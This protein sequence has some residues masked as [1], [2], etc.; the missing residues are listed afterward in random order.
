MKSH[1]EPTYSRRDLIVAWLVAREN[2]NSSEAVRDYHQAAAAAFEKAFGIKLDAPPPSDPISDN[3]GLDCLFLRTVECYENTRSPFAGFMAAGRT[4]V[5]IY[6]ESCLPL[7]ET[8]SGLRD[9]YLEMMVKIVDEIWKED[10]D[11]S[12]T[13]SQLESCGH[14]DWNA[15][16]PL[17]DW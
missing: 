16:N 9:D 2:K 15:P 3:D 1:K 8:I 5:R 6:R 14:P 11:R 17:D 4:F 12:I 7:N 10:R 13:R